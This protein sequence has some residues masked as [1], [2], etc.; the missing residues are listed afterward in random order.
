MFS[1]IE[2]GYSYFRCD[3]LK[4]TWFK[5]STESIPYSL[6]CDFKADCS[7]SLDEKFCEYYSRPCDEV[8]DLLPY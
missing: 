5:C 3:K 6:V 8:G 1:V 4:Q 7:D 2:L